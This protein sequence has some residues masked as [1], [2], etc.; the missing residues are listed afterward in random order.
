ML[1][2]RDEE[3]VGAALTGAIQSV[4]FDITMSE[5]RARIGEF[6]LDA[7]LS[8]LTPDALEELARVAKLTMIRALVIR[9]HMLNPG[10]TQHPV[11]DIDLSRGRDDNQRTW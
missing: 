11:P 6:M 7:E 10:A 8:H 1:S 9:E 2:H 3:F 4:R 5:A